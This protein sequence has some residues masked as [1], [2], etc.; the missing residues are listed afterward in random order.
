MTHGERL[1][2]V[3]DK[4]STMQSAVPVGPVPRPIDRLGEGRIVGRQHDRPC[5]SIPRT[6]RPLDRHWPTDR[7]GGVHL[8]S[9]FGCIR[10]HHEQEKG[11]H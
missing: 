5:R 9:K 10:E 3:L 6:E 11:I 4:H 2:P 1:R 7:S 8:Y